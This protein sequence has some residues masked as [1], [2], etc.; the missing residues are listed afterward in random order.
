MRFVV[1]TAGASG[2]A[3]TSLS[4][5]I[6]SRTHYPTRGEKPGFLSYEPS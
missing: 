4:F 6:A 5:I 2:P 3:S 1:G